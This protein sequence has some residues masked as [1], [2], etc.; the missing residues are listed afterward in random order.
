MMVKVI[1]SIGLHLSQVN[2]RSILIHLPRRKNTFVKIP[3]ASIGVIMPLMV[4][5]I[6]TR[7]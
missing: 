4:T 6:G 7:N 1:L 2:Q 5:L 3:I